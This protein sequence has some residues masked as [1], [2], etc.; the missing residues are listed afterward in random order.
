MGMDTCRQCRQQTPDLY[1]TCLHC[2][3]RQ[4]PLILEIMYWL[5]VL[6]VFL[7]LSYYWLVWWGVFPE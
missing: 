5:S 6:A 3:A 4:A 7:V 1:N 2:G